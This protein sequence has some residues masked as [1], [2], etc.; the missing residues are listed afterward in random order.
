MLYIRGKSYGPSI[1]NHNVNLFRVPGER[2]HKFNRSMLSLKKKCLKCDTNGHIN[3]APGTVKGVKGQVIYMVNTDHSSFHR[4][5]VSNSFELPFSNFSLHNFVHVCLTLF[6]KFLNS[7][8]YFL[9]R[10]KS[11]T[12]DV[13]LNSSHFHIKCNFSFEHRVMY[14]LTWLLNIVKCIMAFRKIPGLRKTFYST[15]QK[16]L[17]KMKVF[18]NNF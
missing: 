7:Q 2:T 5:K 4:W 12:F 15:L 17:N 9:I 1:F 16:F 14:L 6:I 10:V 11:S 13:F 8:F 18:S 3:Y